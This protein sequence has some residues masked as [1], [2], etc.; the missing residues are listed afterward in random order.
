MRSA[1]PHRPAPHRRKGERRAGGEMDG[2]GREELGEACRAAWRREQSRGSAM[3]SRRGAERRGHEREE[4]P[5][6]FHPPSPRGRVVRPTGDALQR[7]AHRGG[8]D[9]PSHLGEGWALSC[10]SSVSGGGPG[11]PAHRTAPGTE[12]R[13]VKAERPGAGP[14]APAAG[15]G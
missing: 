8:R 10:R 12:R 4:R 15:Q 6:N 14:A 7:S 2:A 5:A 13:V 11:L 9:E 1:S 3:A